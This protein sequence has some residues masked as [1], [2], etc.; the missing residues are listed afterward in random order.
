MFA[1][2]T[3]PKE[4]DPSTWTNNFSFE[5]AKI[6]PCNMTKPWPFAGTYNNYNYNAS[7]YEFLKNFS[8]IAGNV[9]YIAPG[10]SVPS[11]DEQ[12]DRVF[13]LDDVNGSQEKLDNLT[14]AEG[15]IIIDAGER[16][17]LTTNASN[18][19]F[20]VVSINNSSGVTVKGLLENFTVLVDNVGE[21]LTFT[22]NLSQGWWPSS[23]FVLIDR[24][25]DH[26]ELWNNTDVFLN[27]K[28]ACKD[29]PD[30]ISYYACVHSKARMFNILNIFRNKT[31]QCRGIILYDSYDYHFMIGI[32]FP[33]LPVFTLNYSVGNFL[34]NNY[35]TTTLTGYANQTYEEETELIAT[36]EFTVS[37]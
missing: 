16:G 3:K 27:I 30:F 33:K 17:D 36:Y 23:D 14:N 29:R 37:F 1:I 5:N 35:D 24:I 21:N 7:E 18:C 9:T 28:A 32:S 26:Y 19:T 4:N 15:A 25:P 11:S 22:Y 20:S 12:Y 8:F 34:R 10:D 2:A 31:K 13:L 6:K